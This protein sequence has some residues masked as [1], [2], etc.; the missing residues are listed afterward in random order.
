MRRVFRVI[1]GSVVCGLII[2]NS[3]ATLSDSSAPEDAD[4]CE[5]TVRLSEICAPG[6]REDFATLTLGD[7]DIAIL[8]GDNWASGRAFMWEES[9][10][11]GFD[12]PIIIEVSVAL[13]GEE[14]VIVTSWGSYYYDLESSG[15]SYR[16]NRN[17]VDEKTGEKLVQWGKL[18]EDLIIWNAKTKEYSK[19]FFKEGTKILSGRLDGGGN[20][21]GTIVPIVNSEWILNVADVRGW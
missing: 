19:F 11:P 6:Y 15:T 9:G 10:Y 1:I 7:S 21:V 5:D 12:Y 14:A 16:E 13:Y 18:G 2:I 4:T 20:S 8:W 3:V 17:L